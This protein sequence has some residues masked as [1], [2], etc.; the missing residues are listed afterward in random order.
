MMTTMVE[1]PTGA[2]VEAVVR[3]VDHTDAQV[4]TEAVIQI[5]TTTETT[6][7]TKKDHQ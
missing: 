7:E 4:R 2:D 3:V 6:T 5:T 1:I